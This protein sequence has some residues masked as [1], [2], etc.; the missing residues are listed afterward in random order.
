MN[1]KNKKGFTLVEL[2]AVIVVLIIIM[3]VAI[4]FIRTYTKR[5]KEKA[6]TVNALS[7][8]KAVNDKAG[9][10]VVSDKI[11]KN[12]LFNLYA[13]DKFEVTVQGT[14]PDSAFVCVKDYKV[15]SAC[16]QYGKNKVEYTNDDVNR[17]SK[18]KCNVESVSCTI[19]PV[20]TFEY[21]GNYQTFEAPRDS[22]Y[23]IDLWGASGGS[24]AD[25]PGGKGAYTSGVIYLSKGDILYFYVGGAG[26]SRTY[27][28]GTGTITGGYNG[29]AVGNVSRTSNT[30]KN[31]SGG[32]ATDVR[33]VSGAWN[34]SSSLA[35]RI[36]VAAGG[37]G[38]YDGDA[39]PVSGGYG[40]ALTGGSGSYLVSSIGGYSSLTPSGGTQTSG[41]QSVNDWNRS[42]YE[43]TYI[44]TFG[45]G[46]TGANSYGGGGGGYWG[47]AS[48]NWKPGAG[49]SSYI[50]GHKGCVAVKSS[51][52][53]APK[54]GCANGTGNIACSYHYSEKIFENTVMKSGNDEMPTHDFSSTMTG[55]EG[56]GYAAI[57][58]GY[59]LEDKPEISN[60]NEFYAFTGSQQKFVAPK[61]AKYKLE[62][63]GAQGGSYSNTY[64]GGYGGYSSGYVNLVAGDILYVYVGGE[65]THVGANNTGDGGYN[66]GGSL[67]QTWSD[68]NERRGTG[69]GA[70][71]IAKKGGVLSSFDA[72]GNGTA[73]ASEVKDI[74]IVAGGGGASHVNAAIEGSSWSYG[75]S[76]GGY[77]GGTTTNYNG[78]PRTGGTQTSSGTLTCDGALGSFGKGAD[79]S[80][81][82]QSGAGGGF[83]GGVSG[84]R[85]GSGGSGYIGNSLLTNKEMYC[86]NC[87]ESTDTDTKTTSVECAESNPT[88]NCAKKGSG[89]AKISIVNE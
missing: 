2:L 9:I 76:G 65:G 71:H 88:P 35:S 34:N 10:D 53:T 1:K 79:T 57:Y 83:Y 19:A 81:G 15:E 45:T 64:F 29:G 70:T 82:N 60:E 78:C 55:N 14:K 20:Q 3:L 46:A 16:L 77:I 50:S 33:L 22:Y 24:I 87:P 8:I 48:G 27:N 80:G 67:K 26:Q 89:F 62:V 30:Q 61:T 84:F 31:S 69:G 25:V 41:G 28:D 17:V 43:N 42:Y 59:Y 56:N 51:T 63:W 4:T 32:G 38:V 72:D 23:K 74:L 21:T 52:S 49:G 13:L 75:G 36:M 54:T 58:Q 5:S 44:G 40:G 73:E 86:Y 47:G 37:G 68:G 7:Y 66:G 6:L 85:G 18:G 11:F 12:G 39:I